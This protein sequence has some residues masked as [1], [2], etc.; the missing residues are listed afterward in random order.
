MTK[1]LKLMKDTKIF[2]DM[3]KPARVGQCENIFI[4]E[5]QGENGIVEK[6][7][8]YEGFCKALVDIA[9]VRFPPSLVAGEVDDLSSL[10]KLS[11]ADGDESMM[12][13]MDEEKSVQ[14]AMSP[15]PKPPPESVGSGSAKGKGKGLT[16][17]SP[18][19]PKGK[20][21]KGKGKSGKGQSSL[22]EKEREA[23]AKAA[24]ALNDVR[25]VVD[26]VQAA[27][28]LRKL[29]VNFLLTIPDWSKRAWS[30]AKIAAMNREAQKYAA[31]TR[32]ASS[33][34]RYRMCRIY[35]NIQH[36][37]TV[38]QGH[39]RRKIACNRVKGMM[40][41]LFEDWLF[42]LRYRAATL[43]N[44]LV[45]K[46]LSRARHTRHMLALLNDQ[47][48]IFK[49]R[50]KR[51][52][53][54]RKKE[55]QSVLYRETKRVNGL[56]ILLKIERKDKRNYSKDYG[57]VVVVYLGD[58]QDTFKFEIEEEELRIFMCVELNVDAVT[59]GDLL[60][61][62]N[63]SKVIDSRLMVKK[64][65]RPGMKPHVVFSRQ[66]LG[67]KGSKVLVRGRIISGDLF[68]CTLYESGSEVSAQCYHRLTST[69]FTCYLK[70]PALLE[71]VTWEYR[72]SCKTEVDRHK[73][74][75]LLRE[76]NKRQ[77]H[78]WII[79][80]ILADTRHKTFRVIFACQL[81]KSRKLA[82]IRMMQCLWRKSLTRKR[83]PAL[84]D[85]V[86]IK[87]KSSPTDDQNCYYIDRRSGESFW[88]KSK[89]LKTWDLPTPPTYRWIDISY[90][91]PDGK[92][93]FKWATQ[94]VNPFT[95]KFS[96]L[97]MDRAARIIQS[98]VRSRQLQ[99]MK[100]HIDFLEKA[101]QII[102]ECRNK[103]EEY[104]GKL[105][106]VMNLALVKHLIWDDEPGARELYL[107]AMEMSDSNPLVTR[108][109]AIYLLQTGEAP[110]VPNR[111][112]ALRLVKDASRRDERHEKFDLAYEVIYR[113]GA[114][115]K[116]R[117]YKKLLAL[118]LAD[119][120]VNDDKQKAE[121]MFRR[122]VAIAPFQEAVLNNWKALR[123]EFPENQA[124]FAPKSRLDLVDTNKGGKK[125]LVH[126]Q[127]SHEDVS[128]AG[129][130]YIESDPDDL[131]SYS[132]WYNP[133]TRES[134]YDQP[135]FQEQWYIRRMRSRFEATTNEDGLEHYYDHLTQAYFQYHAL[136]DTYM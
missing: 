120:Y 94:F 12:D 121:R 128:W 75:P 99:P 33:Y 111:E 1:W 71:W 123:D 30:D 5:R 93:E 72:L 106:N 91:E 49:M 8:N 80:R 3:K 65:L 118:G 35:N 124:T 100:V 77:L 122:A 34:R 9:I 135:N 56:L 134:T 84:L 92:G 22:K 90:W 16:G 46:Y 41:N 32:L 97:S 112:K 64:S 136:T 15:E 83:M 52:K 24:K 45:R 44:S 79:D 60:D 110:T 132:Y 89:L 43:F 69:V 6:Y 105:V 108:A 13:E 102:R 70:K 20:G 51:K 7:I 126:G 127:L 85:M 19:P 2:P 59:V 114:M 78:A 23:N 87:V 55:R 31:A 57:V 133:A 119:F 53:K 17:R 42:R 28:A 125:K 66:A 81:E 11:L 88:E 18:S 10:G 63:L 61:K 115:R 25:P 50:R 98:V 4:R 96:H 54:L 73:E 14:T 58:T 130:I 38:M 104:P 26:P 109:Y 39:A 107:T 116:P 129:W 67:Q 117:D 37:M 21:G 131:R 86:L 101:I 82:A 48:K 103:F 40:K 76:D 95:G 47:I 27:I 113:Y 29:V 68:V 62:R 74:P 36:S